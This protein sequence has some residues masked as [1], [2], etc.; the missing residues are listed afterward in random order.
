MKESLSLCK[1]L[2]K[3]GY[4]AYLAGGCVRDMLQGLKPKDYDISTSAHPDEIEKIFPHTKPV[5]KQ[6]GVILV[7]G[8]TGH[9]EVATF[10]GEEEYLDGR[11]PKK[12]HFVSEKED[13]LRRDF[14]INGLFYNPINKKIIDYVKGKNDLKKKIIR[15]IGSPGKRIQEDHLR[16]LRAVRFK[17]CLNFKYEAKTK[18]AIK[19]YA[20]LIKTVSSE[21]IKDELDKIMQSKYRAK[22]IEDLSQLGILKYILPEVEEMKK[23]EQPPA[24]HAEG[25]V[26][27]HTVLSLKKLPEKAKKEIAW[28]VF[29][30]DLGK[31]EKRK[32][33]LHPVKGMRTVFYGHIEKSA[34]MS[35]KICKRLK[36]SKK[37]REEV[38]FLVNEH[39]KHKDIP[40]M[41]ICRQ[42]QW[43][44][45]PL[46]P[47][48]LQVWKADGQASWLGKKDNIDLSLYNTAKKL[49]K[50]ELKRPKP[51]KPLLDG[52]EVMKILNISSGPKV[53]E[54]L[55]KL[56]D[57]QLEEKVK[58]KEKAKKFIK[59]LK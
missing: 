3:K 13:A 25:N 59:Q 43:A 34:E 37:E 41:K 9:F 5:G 47:E 12:I 35:E 29:F 18:N 17:N 30:H 19:K 44:M 39:L 21:R 27:T 46:F 8:K 22:G 42:R 45:H 53:G 32:E 40:K 55:K 48:L 11:R 14:T 54:I 33:I 50:D 49:Y 20:H 52:F 31:P 1:T 23:C 10:R 16:I 36:F 38:V 7:I 28:A 26:F 51:P 2:N 56:M 24:Y 58:D 6:F 57:A 4:V 15:F